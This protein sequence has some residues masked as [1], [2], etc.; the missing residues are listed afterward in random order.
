MNGDKSTA[1][2]I[3]YRWH[4]VAS[5]AACLAFAHIRRHDAC[6]MTNWSLRQIFALILTVFVTVGL[7]ASVVQASDMALKMSTSSGMS[8]N[9]HGDCHDCDGGNFGKSKTM[10]CTVACVAPVLI[11]FPQIGHVIFSA[12]AKLSP[13]KADLLV[14]GTSPPEPFPPR[15]TDLV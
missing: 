15:S 14:G 6:A 13:D 12:A 10:V 1:R 5:P 7:N 2:N 11:A 3:G 9:S 4:K 8:V